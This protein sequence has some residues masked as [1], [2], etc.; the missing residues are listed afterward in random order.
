MHGG[1]RRRAPAV[2]RIVGAT[3]LAAQVALAVPGSARAQA[4]AAAGEAT[5]DEARARA[6]DLKSQGDRAIGEMQYTEA[7]AAYDASYRLSPT[8]EALFNRGRAHQ[9]LGRYPEALADFERFA[10]EAPADIRAKVPGID[11]IVSEVRGRVAYLT[12]KST[13]HRAPS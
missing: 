5:P 11:R 4:P 9:F 1:D 8:W 2:T 7:L 10:A 6:R 12:I 3:L 13:V